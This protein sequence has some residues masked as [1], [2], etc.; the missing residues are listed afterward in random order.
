MP[1]TTNTAAMPAPANCVSQLGHAEGSTPAANRGHTETP[2]SS[3]A[4]VKHA[5]GGYMRLAPGVPPAVLTRLSSLSHG[6]CDPSPQAACSAAIAA[7]TAQSTMA[8]SVIM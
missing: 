6:Q 1:R 3:A 8:S 7:S 5:D 2:A 4:T